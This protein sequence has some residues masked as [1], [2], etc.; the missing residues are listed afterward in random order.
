MNKRIAICLYGLVGQAKTWKDGGYVSLDS[1]EIVKEVANR[2]KI[3]CKYDGEVDFYIHSWD[4]G[5]EDELRALYKPKNLKTEKQIQFNVWPRLFLEFKKI[6]GFRKRCKFLYNIYFSY[7]KHK[8]LY[9][10]KRIFAALSRWY[11][12]A[13]SLKMCQ[14]YSDRSGHTYDYVISARL[15]LVLLND[16]NIS[17]LDPQKLNLA[18]FNRTPNS[19]MGIEADK[20]NLTNNEDKLSDLIFIS[21]MNIMYHLIDI[22]QNFDN[23]AIN[24]HVAAYEAFSKA[25][26]RKDFNYFIFPWIE[27]STVKAHFYSWKLGF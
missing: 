22:Y 26:S 12:T 1:Q 14:E 8:Q 3:R 13:E 27:F 16:L 4:E 20:S 18:H 5:Y 2:W 17:Q 19:T 11:S 6:K 24:P 7:P 21:N 10:K 15:D 9:W 25:I 23:Y